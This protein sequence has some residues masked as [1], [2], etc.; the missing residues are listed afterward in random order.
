MPLLSTFGCPKQRPCPNNLGAWQ[1]TEIWTNAALSES[2]KMG[3]PHDEVGTQKRT[4]K[5]NN[6]IR[7][8]PTRRPPSWQAVTTTVLLL[9]LT[10]A[11]YRAAA[12]WFA[13]SSDSAPLPPGTLAR[14]PLD[15]ED[16]RGSEVSLDDSIVRRTDTDDHVNRTYVHRNGLELVSLFIAYGVKLR[17]LAPHRPEVCYPEAGWTLE[18]SRTVEIPL[19]NGSSL[20]CQVHRFHRGGLEQKRITVLNYYVVD[21]Q[22][23]PD[24]SLLRSKVWK[25][26]NNQEYAAQVQIVASDSI[27]PGNSEDSVRRFAVACAQPIRSLFPSG[28]PPGTPP[29]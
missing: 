12:H 7:N 25:R 26:T 6:L 19:E 4:R 15:L 23:C 13:R 11:S 8:E 27:A 24:V 22:Y 5:W 2:A 21:G 17:D 1:T 3:D 14:L 16:W 29:S 18:N 9:T 10:G 20:S 28:D